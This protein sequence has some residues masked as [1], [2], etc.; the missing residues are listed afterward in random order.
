MEA[1]PPR[2]RRTPRDRFTPTEQS[3][4]I[5]LSHL[6]ILLVVTL[7]M[8]IGVGES[9]AWQFLAGEAGICLLCATI[10]FR[11]DSFA[12]FAGHWEE[13]WEKRLEQWFDG[14]REKSPK[15]IFAVAFVL[16]FV[17]LTPLLVQTGG[18]VDSPF[19]QLALAFAVF[20]P[21]LANERTT[22]A[23]ALVTSVLYY[24]GMILVY[25]DDEFTNRPGPWVFFA[26]STLI[27]VATVL[28]SM[29]E[30][31]EADRQRKQEMRAPAAEEGRPAT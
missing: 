12:E 9:P 25:G 30:R 1:T 22:I 2:V 28:L 20:A 26:V 21:L 6:A 29:L 10:A 15:A 19:A 23:V 17:A 4:A 16:Q 13:G 8:V 5:L 7:I 31:W 27:L 24:F 14:W 11:L 3:V 18:P